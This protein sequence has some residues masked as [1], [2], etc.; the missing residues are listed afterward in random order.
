MCTRI[1]VWVQAV[2]RWIQILN[3][4]GN[5]GAESVSLSIAA[6]ASTAHDLW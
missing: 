6:L 2:A 3:S 1:T 5:S 4:V